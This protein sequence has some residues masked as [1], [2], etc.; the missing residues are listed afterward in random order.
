M[1]SFI[2]CDA[3]EQKTVKDKWMCQF[4]PRHLSNMSNSLPMGEACLSQTTPPL[5]TSPYIPLTSLT[6][7]LFLSS[8]LWTVAFYDSFFFFCRLIQILNVRVWHVL[9]SPSSGQNYSLQLT[10]SSMPEQLHKMQHSKEQ[11]W[12]KPCI[13]FLCLLSLKCLLKRLVLPVRIK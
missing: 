13:K 3:Q 1:L 11:K 8:P 4:W 7:I 2:S 12:A 5:T 6:Y 9:F 10:F